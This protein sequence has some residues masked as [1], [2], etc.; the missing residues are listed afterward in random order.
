MKRVLRD[1]PIHKEFHSPLQ[2]SVWASENSHY[3]RHPELPFLG[4]LGLVEVHKKLVEVHKKMVQP[5]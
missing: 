5:D 3:R 1:T 2:V 4:F